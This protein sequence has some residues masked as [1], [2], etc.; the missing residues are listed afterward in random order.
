MAT[1]TTTE[2]KQS[3]AEKIA[4][5]FIAQME[6][7][8]KPWRKTWSGGLSAATN[9]LTGKQYRGIN[10]MLLTFLNPFGSSYWMTYKQAIELGGSVKKGSTG[11][12]C[13][14]WQFR[15]KK[16]Q[17]G[18]LVYDSKGIKVQVPFASGFTVFNYEQTEGIKLPETILKPESER[19]AEAESIIQGYLSSPNGPRFNETLSGRAFY[20]PMFH[21]V[22]VPLK[23]QFD[24][25]AA[26]YATVFHEL[27]HATSKE[28]GRDIMLNEK[29]GDEYAREELVAELTAAMLCA[30]VGIDCEDQNENST[31]YLMGWLGKI[32]ENPNYL[33]KSASLAQKAMDAILLGVEKEK[34][35]EDKVLE[36]A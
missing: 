1:Q 26:Y 29:G 5:G 36:M 28:L 12:A 34:E 24:S 14:Y 18:N 9:L 30:H 7:G 33:I 8:V 17:N 32:K 27:A 23:A 4:A 15:D 13:F 11:T 16:D 2:V 21:S 31:A 3:A 25:S 22:T 20:S 35:T 6:L 19:L 10:R